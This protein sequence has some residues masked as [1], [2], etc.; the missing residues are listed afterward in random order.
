MGMHKAM[1]KYLAEKGGKKIHDPLALA[2]ALDE[3]VCTLAEVELDSRGP[4]DDEW[5][6]WLSQGSGT[7][8]SVDY[9]EAK[10]RRT[11]LHDGFVPRPLP[12]RASADEKEDPVV[13]A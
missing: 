8:I 6:C 3:S 13:S 7:W 10:F 5:G 9:D 11:L 4:K 12:K 1:S 2:V